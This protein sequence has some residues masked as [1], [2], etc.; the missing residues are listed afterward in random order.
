MKDTKPYWEMSRIDAPGFN[1][2]SWLY[3]PENP[4]AKTS[5]R[6]SLATGKL[7]KFTYSTNP[8]RNSNRAVSRQLQT[9]KTPQPH[10]D[11][12]T[13]GFR[14]SNYTS[15]PVRPALRGMTAPAECGRRDIFKDQHT[16]IQI[17]HKFSGCPILSVPIDTGKKPKRT[18]KTRNVQT[19]EKTEH[20]VPIH[21]YLF[22]ESVDPH[23]D[24]DPWGY[25]RNEE[26]PINSK[27]FRGIKINISRLHQ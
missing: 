24:I 6:S 13:I 17:T 21:E 10:E 16:P 22:E 18:I 20:D 7:E 1:K 15:V 9:P 2:Y 25:T 3:K 8:S 27:N 12:T 26:I 23:E 11:M 19:R 14:V 4:R 5:M